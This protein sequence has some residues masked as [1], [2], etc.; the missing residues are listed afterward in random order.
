MLIIISAHIPIF[1]LQRHEGRI[2]QP[3]AWSVTSALVTSL[4]LSLTLVPLLCYWL[5]RKNL[6]HEENRVIHW[7]KAVYEPALSW[8]LDH[9]KFVIGAAIAALAASLALGAR[10]GTEFLPELNEGSVWINVP[11]P[12]SVSVREAQDMNRRIRAELAQIPEINTVMSKAGRPEDGTDPKLINMA[13]FL[14]DMKPESEWKRGLTK[15]QIMDE[16]EERLERLPGVDASF[17][18]PI[19]DNVLESISQIDGQIVIKVFGDDLAV[20]RELATKTLGAVQNVQGVSRAFVDR[21]GELPQIQIRIDRAA[22]GRYGLNVA[23]IEEA[24]ETTLGGHV[25]TQLWEGERRFDVVLRLKGD[26]RTLARMQDVLVTAPSGAHIPLSQVA[27]FKTVGGSMNISRE[28]GRRVLSIGIFIKDRDMGSV[29]A[30]MKTRVAEK[31]KLPPGYDITWSG[32]FEN[33]ERAMA[34]L[35]IIVPISVLII[36]LFLFDAFKSFKSA[37]LILLNIPFALIGGIVALYVTG[38]PLSVSAAIGFIA[39]FGQA[40]LNGVVMVTYFNQLR[41][42][43]M[44]PRDAV[45]RGSLVRLRTVLMTGLLAMLGLLPMALSHDI[46]SETQKPLAVVVIGGLISATLLTLI[47]LPTLYLVFQQFRRHKP[48]P[49]AQGRAA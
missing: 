14:V 12:P 23:D 2:F 26:E 43:G 30:D 3:M 45:M 32:E 9:R 31:V 40:V 15:R 38:I 41:S 19:R 44:P 34:R 20:L 16:M 5:L 21:L 10:L 47:V 37:L 13:E 29:V 48:R 42:A 25:T 24:V 6:P 8:A 39:L 27:E 4:I 33:Q 22:A 11:Y 17:S 49:H 46:G 36:F 18:Q 35:A 1:T 28:N 7:A